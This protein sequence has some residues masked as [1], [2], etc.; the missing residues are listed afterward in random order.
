VLGLVAPD[1]HGEERRLLFPPAGDGHPE[2]GP[3][4]PAFG[5][6][7]LGV[8]GEV[9]DDKVVA[10]GMCVPSLGLGV[11]LALLLGWSFGL[12]GCP[13]SRADVVRGTG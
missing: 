11:V 9:A 5:V 7:D 6:A 8:V 1:D 4:D 3:G 13:G 10:S 2:P 12:G